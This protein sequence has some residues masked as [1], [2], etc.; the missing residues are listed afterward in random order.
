MREQIVKCMFIPSQRGFV[1]PSVSWAHSG[2]GLC[3]CHL[4]L[5]ALCV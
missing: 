5:F 4:Y 1:I 3:V 2:H